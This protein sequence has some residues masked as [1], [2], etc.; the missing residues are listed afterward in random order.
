MSKPFR[1]ASAASLVTLAT[2]I[3]GCATPQHQAVGVSSVANGDIGLATR[4]VAAL[5]SNDIPTAIGLAERAVEKTPEDATIRA[6][7]GNA[8]FAGGRFA[9]AEAAYK[10]SLSI[11]A[12]QPQVVLKLALVQIAQG[13]NADAVSLLTDNDNLL[14]PSDYGL[15]LALAGRPADAVSVLESVARAPGADSRVRQNLALAYGLVGDWTEART[16]A[17]QDVPANQLDA[18]IQQWMQ[19]AKPAH[20]SDQVAALTGV[21][22][23][24]ID[25]GQPVNLALNKA[26]A[27]QAQARPVAPVPVPAP[28]FTPLPQVAEVAPPAP[29]PAD[30]ARVPAQVADAT[31]APAFT[32]APAIAIDEPVKPQLASLTVK[33]PPARPLLHQGKS[34]TVVQLGAYS[35]REG[36]EAA[37]AKLTKRYPKL[38]AYAPMTARFD[39]PKGTV[40]RLAI[41]GFSSQHEAVARCSQLKS[42][43]GACFVRN[44]AGDSPVQ[45]ASR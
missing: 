11:L 36:V 23:A 18:R 27:R 7:L 32:P 13:K 40:Y 43:G 16:V 41:K 12:N 10:D 6:L 21:R 26:D 15:A 37:W 35:S 8:Y 9:S 25:P 34:N 28:A 44:V 2:M 19:L 30:V 17:A 4:A 42:S 38:R 14:D 31:P 20:A 5:N 22:A 39:S 33:V 1:F 24:T 3:A 29:P 45:F